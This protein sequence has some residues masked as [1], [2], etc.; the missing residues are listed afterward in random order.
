MCLPPRNELIIHRHWKVVS[1]VLTDTE[2]MYRQVPHIV[3][4]V[5]VVVIKASAEL[6]TLVPTEANLKLRRRYVLCN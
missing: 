4:V 1:R 6:H 5:V 3:V 2:S